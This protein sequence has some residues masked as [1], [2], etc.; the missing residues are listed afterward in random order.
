MGVSVNKAIVAGYVTG[1]P[2]S[3][4]TAK[5]I[6]CTRFTVASNYVVK[7]HKETFYANVVAWGNIGINCDKY[8]KKGSAV[9]VEGRLKLEEWT[10]NNGVEQHRTSIYAE[11]V[12]FLN[13]FDYRKSAETAGNGAYVANDGAG[14]VHY[15][16]DAENANL[17]PYGVF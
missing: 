9:M 2:K 4:T 11:S 6:F 15:G 14:L 13:P 8:L 1:E 7:D 5:G 3:R 12:H 10:D 16:K 17:P